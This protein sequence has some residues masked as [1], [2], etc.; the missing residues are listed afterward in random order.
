MDFE[1]CKHDYHC[2]GEYRTDQYVDLPKQP[3]LAHTQALIVVNRYICLLCGLVTDT[4]NKKTLENIKD[5]I[6]EG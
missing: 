6:K 4:I 2:I 3:N 1:K 5:S